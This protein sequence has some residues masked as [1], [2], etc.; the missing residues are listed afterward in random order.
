M[1]IK[2]IHL[3]NVASFSSEGIDIEELSKINFIYGSNGTGKTTLTR[4]LL[5]IND[6]KY[7]DCFFEPSLNDNTKML[8]YNRDFVKE[9][10]EQM[11]S[12]FTLGK[13]R[14]EKEKEIIDNNN[15]IEYKLE[16]IRKLEEKKENKQSQIDEKYNALKPLCWGIKNDYQ[17]YFNQVFRGFHSS[18]EKLTDRFIEIFES[19][20]DKFEARENDEEHRKKIDLLK[21][22]STIINNAEKSE[23]DE[24]PKI[25]IIDEIE[26]NESD[27]L[28]QKNIVGKKDLDISKL[29]NKLDNSDWI[30]EGK[31]YLENNFD[32]EKK[33]YICPFCQQ[34]ITNNF[35]K[36]INEFFDNQYNEDISELQKMYE[37]YKDYSNRLREDIFVT[38]IDYE[39]LQYDKETIELLKSQINNNIENNLIKMKSKLE[40]PSQ[41]VEIKSSFN[42]I[43]KYNNQI[44]II[45]SKIK[46]YNHMISNLD[47]E[48]KELNQKIWITLTQKI[49]DRL[50]EYIETRDEV[51]R[52]IDNVIHIIKSEDEHVVRLKIKNQEIEKTLTSVKPT[53]NKINRTLESLG[54]TNFYLRTTEDEKH[55]RIIRPNGDD[56]T[57]TLSEGEKGLITFL[58]FYHLI[59]GVHEHQ[60]NIVNNKI[61]VIDDP[62]SSFDSNIL[63][64]ISYLIKHLLNR[65]RD[66]SE[67]IIKQVLILTHNIYF[68]K[69]ISFISSRKSGDCRRD[70][71]YYILRKKSNIT[72]IES[73]DNNPIK[74]TYQHLW[75]ELKKER[76]P[77]SLQ[78]TMRRIIEYYFKILG[79]INEDDIIECFTGE[80]KIIC[81]SLFAWINEGSH[82]V[83]DDINIQIT[84]ENINKYKMIFKTIFEKTEHDKHY[85]MMMN[86]QD[87]L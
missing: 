17:N 86:N 20:M 38:E 29:I 69:E 19:N 16:K 75:N 7:K 81:R 10:F 70:T 24:R 77:V 42:I 21:E 55:Y 31:E 25:E 83:F 43:K 57:E 60:D 74:T 40:K 52:I 85:N 32:K 2:K 22:K 41:K 39:I 37:Q 76:D 47:Q 36:D 45:N 53:A 62:V 48:Q 87:L 78:N 18:K 3:Q 79:G 58:Y 84:D 13:D 26:K 67:D 71:N 12:V 64:V 9:N 50:K 5:N 15:T 82:E 73:F 63:F 49:Q 35:E 51:R 14:S 23:I 4:S 68:F 46:K 34:K 56:A 59:E 54:F 8:V 1:I 66:D 61:I 44:E 72:Y 28:L 80:D 27:Q 65:V 6:S 30:L 11:K 33:E